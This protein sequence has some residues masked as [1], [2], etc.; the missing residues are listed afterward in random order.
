MLKHIFGT[1]TVT[2]IRSIHEGVEELRQRN[3]VSSQLIYVKDSGKINAEA[4]ANLSSV[5][6]DRVI[7]SHDQFLSI[8]KDMFWLNATLQTESSMFTVT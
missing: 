2:D 3:S 6:K 4:I 5:V 1:A 8:A 7:R